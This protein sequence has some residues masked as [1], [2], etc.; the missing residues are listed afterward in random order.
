MPQGPGRP[1]GRGPRG[2]RRGRVHAAAALA[3]HAARACPSR[4]SSCCWPGRSPAA[5]GRPWRRGRWAA[6]RAGAAGRAGRPLAPRLPGPLL[7][8]SSCRSTSGGEE[9]NSGQRP[10]FMLMPGARSCYDHSPTPRTLRA[11]KMATM[12]GPS[13]VGQRL[14]TSCGRPSTS[15]ALSPAAGRPSRGSA[16]VALASSAQMATAHPKQAGT[17]GSRAVRKLILLR[18]AESDSRSP[19]RD[20]DRRVVEGLMGCFEGPMAHGPPWSAPVHQTACPT[21][22]PQHPRRISERAC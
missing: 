20:H 18:H 6:S 10:E 12:M 8:P 14:S 17:G 1:V 22:L 21:A 2:P 5:A 3:L 15:Y 9:R 11:R 7:A 19:V 13:V 16:S 4:P